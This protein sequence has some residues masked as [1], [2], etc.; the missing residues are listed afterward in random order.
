MLRHGEVEAPLT[1]YG[2]TFLNFS[3]TNFG[4]V[5]QL[6]KHG[7]VER[8]PNYYAYV[9]H[10]HGNGAS[11]GNSQLTIRDDTGARH[12]IRIHRAVMEAF[13]P[14][15]QFSHEIG[16]PADVWATLPVCVTSALQFC[17]LVNHIDGNPKNNTV[18]NLE[19][20]T[21]MD[22]HRK[23]RLLLSS[24]PALAPTPTPPEVGR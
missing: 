3:I 14:L 6:K 8:V 12:R 11:G 15:A 23:A 24:S 2:T 5:F 18:Q 1:R 7:W 17:V 13:K 21:P 9:R 20:S 4:R 22:N 10:D 19:W 16:I